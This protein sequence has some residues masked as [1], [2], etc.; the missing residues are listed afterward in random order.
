[1]KITIEIDGQ[2]QEV[3]LPDKVVE[4]LEKIAERNGISL[5]AALQ[6]AIVNENF[7]EEAA[8]DGKLLVEKDDKFQ[9]LVFG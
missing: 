4:A 7:I 5:Q 6:Q 2:P 8:K 1:M 3:E 9:E